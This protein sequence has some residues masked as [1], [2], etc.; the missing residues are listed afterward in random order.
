MRSGNTMHEYRPTHRLKTL[1]PADLIPRVFLVTFEKAP[2]KAFVWIVLAQ[3]GEMI[4]IYDKRARMYRMEP[5]YTN[6]VIE[7]LEEDS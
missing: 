7:K 1:C 3:D 5:G 2:S 6:F 4:G